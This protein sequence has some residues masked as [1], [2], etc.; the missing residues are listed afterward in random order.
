MIRTDLET[1]EQRAT[2]KSDSTRLQYLKQLF[3]ELE[4]PF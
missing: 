2:E 4:K 1:L 3:Q